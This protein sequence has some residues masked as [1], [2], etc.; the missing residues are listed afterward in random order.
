MRT[1]GLGAALAVSV[2]LLLVVWIVGRA[3]GFHVSLLGS[4]G[5]TVLLTVVVNVV[6][7]AMSRRNRRW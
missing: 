4:L 6:L 3:T 5:L 1:F 7:G 2:I